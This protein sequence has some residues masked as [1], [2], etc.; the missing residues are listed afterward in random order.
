MSLLRLSAS[1]EVLSR[2]LPLKGKV[3]EGRVVGKAGNMPLLEVGDVVFPAESKVFL[4]P[5][6]RVS[7]WVKGLSGNKLHLQLLSQEDIDEGFFKLGVRDTPEARLSYK[8]LRS[9]GVSFKRGDVG[10]L[11]KL[12]SDSLDP[13]FSLELIRF[14][15]LK[16]GFSSGLLKF[17]LSLGDLSSLRELILKMLLSGDES[18][19]AFLKSIIPKVDGELSSAIANF[20]SKSGILKF[21]GLSELLLRAGEPDSVRLLGWIFLPRLLSLPSREEAWFIYLWFPL[22][23]GERDLSIPL[24]KKHKAL[25][26][27]KGEEEKYELIL[28]LK[29][30]GKI[31]V[32]FYL[33]RGKIWITFE[34][35]NEKTLFALRRRLSELL[36]SLQSAGYKVG[37][38]SSRP[39]V[40]SR[41]IESEGLDLRI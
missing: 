3:I 16:L 31:R 27:S 14:L 1:R 20:L 6:S 17:L 39:M 40:L 38:L 5:G 4:K 37:G 34:A 19:R 32:L 35:E 15:S 7:L 22:L 9:L 12:I 24:L 18:L 21:G 10:L 13:Y 30:L 11:A 33:F 29:T 41:E 23:S 28:E 25:R 2:L 8:F 36:S 26:S